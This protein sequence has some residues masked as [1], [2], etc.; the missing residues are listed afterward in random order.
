MKRNIAIIMS[1]MMILLVST[2][3]MAAPSDP[4]KDEYL[5][6]GKTFEEKLKTIQTREAYNQLLGEHQKSLETLLKKV[7]ASPANDN[8][9]LLMGKI[10]YD[11]Q[12][13]AEATKIFEALIQK[14]SPLTKLAQF[15]KVKILLDDDKAEEGLALFRQIENTVDKTDEY[16]DVL[17]ILAFSVKDS[18]T[19][20]EYSHKFLTAVGKNEKFAEKKIMIY[21][22]LSSIQKDKGNLKEAIR[23][24]ETAKAETPSEEGKKELDGTLKRLKMMGSPAPE[25]QAANWLN[26]PAALKLADLKGKVVVIDFW[27]PWCGPCRRVIPTLIE[28]YNQLKDK[29]LVVIGFTRI[30][31][32]YSDDIQNKGNVTADVEQNLIK[33]FLTRH[34]IT[35]PIAIANNLDIF[36]AYSVQAIPTLIVIDKKGNINDIRVGSGDEAA[37]SKKIDALLK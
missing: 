17:M 36:N 2:W 12:K 10:L 23:I 15:E 26:S 35:Y 4:L 33:E 3:L 1:M 34:K 18:K 14:K 9:E 28:K 6:L 32:R 37:L 8:K 29:G 24:L 16:F 25:I 19:K 5:G 20:E 31:G 27:A 11:L 13:K 22:N 30:Y 21:D 7:E